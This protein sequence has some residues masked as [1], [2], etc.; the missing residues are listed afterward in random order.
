MTQLDVNIE[1]LFTA[2]GSPEK[3]RIEELVK[4]IKNKYS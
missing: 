4:N 2:L 1:K 3:E